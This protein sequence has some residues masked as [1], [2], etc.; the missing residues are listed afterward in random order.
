MVQRKCHALYVGWYARYGMMRVR[1][2]L[3]VYHVGAQSVDASHGCAMQGRKGVCDVA[4]SATPATL[5]EPETDRETTR[6][7]AL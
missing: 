5:C 2:Y 1:L 7:T 3:D 4:R 6:S